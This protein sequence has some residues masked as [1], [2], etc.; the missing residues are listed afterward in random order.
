MH[1]SVTWHVNIK[2]TWLVVSCVFF[3]W[4]L[5]HFWIQMSLMYVLNLVSFLKACHISMQRLSYRSVEVH[6]MNP[7]YGVCKMIHCLLYQSVVVSCD[8]LPRIAQAV[9][10]Y[11]FSVLLQSQCCVS[12]S[13][14]FIKR[15]CLYLHIFY[16]VLV[17]FMFYLYGTECPFQAVVF[18]TLRDTVLILMLGQVWLFKSH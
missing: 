7:P 16:A 1:K 13:I 3:C 11:L 17:K 6:C 9:L 12:K 10:D 5:D 4:L 8:M 15:W 14:Q 18:Q 2:S